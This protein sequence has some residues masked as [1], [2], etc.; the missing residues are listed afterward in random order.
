[1]YSRE[2]IA[3]IATAVG[4]GAVAVVRVSGVEA[5]SVANRIVRGVP[6]GRWRPRRLNV[7]RFVD[8]EERVLDEGLA[9][10]MPAPHSYTGEDV[11]EIHCHGGVVVAR[12]V[13]GAAIAAG[14]RPAER[15][16][17]TLRAFLNGKLDLAQAEAVA[18]LIAAPSDAALDVAVAQLGGALTR[19]LEIP[20]EQLVG[21]A[22]H[23]EVAID[24]SEEDVGK[25]D[26]AELAEQAERIA[27]ELRRLAA[28][29]SRGRVLR[30]GLRVAIVGKP[31]VGKSSLLNRLLGIDRAIV[32]PIPGTTRDVIEETMNIDGLAVVLADTAGLRAAN[33]E[34][35]LIGIE[36]T[37][38]A[39]GAADLLIVMF[40]GAR[41]WTDE[42]EEVLNATRH[43]NR[44]MLIN[45]VDLELSL[46]IPA[47]VRDRDHIISASAKTGAGIDLLKSE[48]LRRAEFRPAD[49][50]GF[51]ITRER[52]RIC[53]EAAATNIDQATAAFRSGIPPDVIAVD[54]MAALDH[55]GEIVGRTSP[56]AV[57]DRI[58]S[59]FCIGK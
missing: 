12:A 47:L 59:E 48:I 44:I 25:F 3:A 54:I 37:A 1:M 49:A 22:A 38:G 42:D 17:F 18:D 9:V 2:T 4:R 10:L 8:A 13:L 5:V 45:K 30:E 40:D 16:E 39:V 27:A 46:K 20:R 6:P 14:A 36:R 19:A 24:F 33:D 51:V 41:E 28:T 26:G 50:G 32:T 31:N 21:I 7:A 56:E 58:F 23:L 34:V 11:V 55:L 29:Y 57:L 15:G 43:N 52:H 35:E 53:L